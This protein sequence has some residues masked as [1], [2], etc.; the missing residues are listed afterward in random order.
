MNAELVAKRDCVREYLQ[1]DL[2]PVVVFW[3]QISERRDELAVEVERTAIGVF[4]VAH[5]LRSNRFSTPNSLQSDISE[6]IESC[7]SRLEKFPDSESRVAVFILSKTPFS[8]PATSSPANIPSWLPKLGG[9]CQCVPIVDLTW[10]A[11]S[12]LN[13]P[14]ANASAIGPLLYDMEGL[15]IELSQRKFNENKSAF[16]SLWG[17]INDIQQKQKGGGTGEFNGVTDYLNKAAE[18]HRSLNRLG[19]RPSAAKIVSF[20]GVVLRLCSA[21]SSDAM[22]QIGESLCNAIGLDEVSVKDWVVPEP[23][24][25]VLLRPT[26]SLPAKVKYGRNLVLTVFTCAQ[27]NTAG[28]HADQY[29]KFSNQIVEGVSRDLLQCLSLFVTQLESRR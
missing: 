17:R 25:S 19:F 26:Q 21:S 18:H 14:I 16:D 9:T 28:A 10:C 6:V 11:D 1:R 5:V 29:P 22:H 4:V 7:R 24:V 8:L 27:L 2:S 3:W 15:L 13:A 20:L 12:P 23:F